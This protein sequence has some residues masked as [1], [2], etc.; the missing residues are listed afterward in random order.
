M[1]APPSTSEAWWA[2][3]WSRLTPTKVALVNNRALP[4]RS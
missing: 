4:D 2:R 3:R 1:A